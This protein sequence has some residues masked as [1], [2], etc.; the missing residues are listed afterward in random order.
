[1]EPRMSKIDEELEIQ[2]LR[3]VI[4]AYLKWVIFLNL[5]LDLDMYD[6]KFVMCV[7][8]TF[9]ILS[10]GF[11]NRIIHSWHFVQIPNLW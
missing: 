8:W 2:A 5:Q 10:G 11:C 1:M 9:A 4:S 3:R 6:V 7:L